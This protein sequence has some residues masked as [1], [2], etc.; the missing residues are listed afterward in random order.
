[1]SN[2]IKKSFITNNSKDNKVEIYVDSKQVSTIDNQC[3]YIIDT[4]EHE[5]VTVKFKNKPK[6]GDI[7]EV[8]VLEIFD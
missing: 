5:K 6:H 1:M 7:N 4:M 8:R 2:L 3:T